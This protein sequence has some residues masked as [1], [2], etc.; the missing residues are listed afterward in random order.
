MNTVYNSFVDVLVGVLAKLQ[1][2]TISFVMSVGPS[3][4]LKGTTWIPLDA[5]HYIIQFFGN[6]S[7]NVGVIK[8]RYNNNKC[9]LYDTLNEDQY[10]VYSRRY[11]VCLHLIEKLSAQF[12]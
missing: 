5:I 11:L 2:P 9:C 6:L 7:R 12:L 4:F 10:I 1:K 8:I 3:F